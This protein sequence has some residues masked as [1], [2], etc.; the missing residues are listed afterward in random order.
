M[1]VRFGVHVGM[2]VRV[3]VHVGMCVCVF[4]SSSVATIVVI[5]NKLKYKYI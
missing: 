4:W 1:C 5:I 3:S 2:C